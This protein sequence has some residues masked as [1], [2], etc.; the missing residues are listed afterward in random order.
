MAGIVGLITQSGHNLRDLPQ[1]IAEM[2][3]GITYTGAE[4]SDQWND[5]CYAISRLHHGILNSAPQPIFNEDKSLCIVMDGEVFDYQPQKQQLIEQGHHF[6]LRENDAEYCLHLYEEYGSEAFAK[7][8]GSFLIALYN[9]KSHELLLVNDRF[10]SRPLFYYYDDKQLIFGTQLRPLLKFP[11]LPRRLDL[12]AIFEFFTFQRI[13]SDRTF[14]KDVK[15]LLPASILRFQ[16]GKIS[17]SRYWTM[18]Y[19]DELH[20]EKYYVE[21]LANSLKR[22]VRRRTRGNYR[23]GILLSGGLDSRAVLAAMD[24]MPVAFTLGDF[25]NTEVRIAQDIAETKGCKHVFL[26]R[27]WNHYPTL[28]EE[29]VDI[30]DGMYRFD[31]AHFLGFL[32]RIREDTDILLH[33]HGLDYTFQGLYLPLAR[34]RIVTKAIP[35]FMLSRLTVATLPAALV[36]KLKYSTKDESPEELFQR[37]ISNQFGRFIN[38]SIQEII[39]EGKTIYGSNVYNAWDYFVLH[40]LF[41]H[42]TFLNFLCVRAYMNERTIIFDNDLFDLYLSMPPGFRLKGRVFRKVLR[43]IAPEFAAI[44]NANTGLRADMPIALEWVLT[45]S[46]GALRKIHILPRP[47]LPHPAFTNGSW[48]KMSE[49]IRYNEKLKQ[50][51]WNTIHDEECINPEIFNVKSI[52]TMF[53]RHLK[54]EREFTALLFLLLTFGRWHKKYGP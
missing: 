28:L 11:D 2:A 7:L 4:L 32:S 50:L 34:L 36:E 31:H 54:G 40:S 47:Q 22:A 26:K 39:I 45:I 41:K 46:R 33:G 15:V 42:F 10:S 17:L 23:F 24:K 9:L 49:L 16:N 19:K 44:L 1:L 37:R 52:E 25:R 43:K 3:K 35:C 51:I 12:Q 27:D 29:A 13:L 48:P 18:Q 53:E 14:Y 20:S 38:R 21:A 5:G 6:R 8:N 30:G